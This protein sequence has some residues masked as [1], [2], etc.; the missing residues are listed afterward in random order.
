MSNELMHYGVLGM[1]W[2]IRRNRS[3]SNTGTQSRRQ[4]SSKKLPT[5][6]K[7]KTQADRK[8]LSTNGKKL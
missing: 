5:K 6:V 4:K 1:K 2:G 7:K 8:R 3:S